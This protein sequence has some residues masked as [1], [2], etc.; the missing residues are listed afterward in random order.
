MVIAANR[1]MPVSAGALRSAGLSPAMDV[2]HGHLFKHVAMSGSTHLA[3]LA[4]RIPL[5][6]GVLSAGDVVMLI[7]IAVTIWEASRLPDHLAVA[8]LGHHSAHNP[9]TGHAIDASNIGSS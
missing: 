8:P 1:G 3:Y 9:N 4:D 2:A 7:G 6:V 5:L